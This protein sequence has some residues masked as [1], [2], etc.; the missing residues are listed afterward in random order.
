MNDSHSSKDSA[1]LSKRA[2]QTYFADASNKEIMGLLIEMKEDNAILKKEICEL[3][4]AVKYLKK[5]RFAEKEVHCNKV[6]S[7]SFDS[8]RSIKRLVSMESRPT[9]WI[10]NIEINNIKAYK[11]V[12]SLK[13]FC[14]TWN[15]SGKI[16]IL[17]DLNLWLQTS[18][19]P[20]IYCIGFQ[21]L[22][23]ESLSESAWEYHVMQALNQQATYIK[24]DLV[25]MVGIEMIIFIKEELQSFVKYKA[26][27]NVEAGIMGVYGNKGG[28]AIR[29]ELYNTSLCFVNCHLTAQQENVLK[30]NEDFRKI[31]LKMK[32]SVGGDKLSISDHEMIFWIGD[33]N[34]RLNDIDI[35]Q[36]K[37]LFLEKN[38]RL[39]MQTDQLRLQ[40]KRKKIFLDYTEGAIRFP[41]TYKYDPGTDDLDSSEKR[42][43]PAWC[44]RILWKGNDCVQLSYDSIHELKFSDHKPVT[45]MLSVQLKEFNDDLDSDTFNE[46]VKTVQTQCM[47]QKIPY[48]KLNNPSM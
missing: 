44:D 4:S 32:F 22:G 17:E 37:Q 35:D 8:F 27:N 33:M 46:F 13:I 36:A 30:R 3:K 1:S 34:Y 40:K 45:S 9:S 39:L 38:F 42:R 28:V 14:A 19:P 21:E 25:K 41:P 7:H 48:D 18:D 43:I 6:L 31:D 5:Q 16:P 29:F 10:K 2:G 20:D 47:E 23:S 15:V 26:K 24:V 12:R 11:N